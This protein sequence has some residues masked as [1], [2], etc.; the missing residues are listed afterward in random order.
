[1]SKNAENIVD[2]QEN[3]LLTV[4]EVAEIL[5]VDDTTVRRW[6]KHGVL[7]AVTLPHLNKRQG[8]RIKRE[9]LNKLLEGTLQP[10]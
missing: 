1:M 8:Y 6:V 2:T 10:A 9:T 3:G 7:S 5:R 4:R